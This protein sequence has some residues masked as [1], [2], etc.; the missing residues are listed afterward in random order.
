[1]AISSEVD[2]E[3]EEEEEEEYSRSQTNF[4]P[5]LKL[6]VGNLPFDVDSSALAGLFEQAGNVEMVEVLTPAYL[7]FSTFNS[8]LFSLGFKFR[9]LLFVVLI[10]P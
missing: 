4:S 5:D 7:L 3:E 8:I 9:I 6:F 2:E 1:M 10:L